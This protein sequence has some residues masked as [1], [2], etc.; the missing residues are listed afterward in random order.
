[1]QR[2]AILFATLSTF[3][4][5]LFITLLFFQLSPGG[6]DMAVAQEEP[7][8]GW[9]EQDVPISDGWITSIAAVD[10]DT[11]WASTNLPSSGSRV[12]MTNNGGSDWLLHTFED[13]ILINTDIYAVNAS[14]LWA[15]GY[16]GAYRSLDGGLTWS[17]VRYLIPGLS[18]SFPLRIKALDANR[19]WFLAWYMTYYNQTLNCGWSLH[20]TSNGG[21]SWTYYHFPNPA[22]NDYGY[23]VAGF[24]VAAD[25]TVWV[26]LCSDPP[27]LLRSTDGG[28]TWHEQALGSGRYIYDIH[29][30]DATHAWAVGC[31]G[32]YR[33]G[34]GKGVILYTSDGGVT[35]NKQYEEPGLTLSSISVVDASTAWVAGEFST[36]YVYSNK[37]VI[38]KTEDG[39]A[40]WATQYTYPGAALFCICAV[41][42]DT[43]WAG[44]RTPS[45]TP[46]VLKTEDG[47]YAYPQI[48]SVSPAS[49]PE[50]CEVTIAGS[51]FG[52]AQSPSYVSFGDVQV[53]E[54]NA[55]SDSEIKVTVPAGLAGEVMVSVFTPEGTSNSMGFTVVPKPLVVSISPGS[56]AQFTWALNV[57]VN[58]SGFQ[59]GARVRLEKGTTAIEAYNLNVVSG[60]QINCTVG[61]FGA[62]PGAYDVVVTNPDG[63]EARLPGAFTV[64]SLCGSGSGTALLMVGLTLG[65]LT[66]A[67][68]ARKRRRR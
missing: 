26:S 67:G 62:A 4:L 31:E 45:Y 66:V 41:D 9:E 21:S 18:E 48:A 56:A 27:V 51:D 60:S 44:G 35:W 39:G 5:T 59:T 46:F 24:D 10:P 13:P 17:R 11:A 64:N 8:S 49:G 36:A 20:W 65:L 63:Q 22:P 58:G 54:C 53:T 15:T 32:A 50:G 16:H 1:M 43:A 2:R 47:G 3:I 52:N 33:P 23:A 68:T 42:A 7:G 34:G 38:L 40:T 6:L 30:V 29:A 28:T 37:A 12:L 19:A 14:V 55:W 57:Q 61:L 25:S